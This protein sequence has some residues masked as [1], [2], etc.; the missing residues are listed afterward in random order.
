MDFI[1]WNDES[2]QKLGTQVYIENT[3]IE[4]SENSI[5]QINVA[6]GELKGEK[7]GYLFLK[8]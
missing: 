7:I 5:L 8:T 2:T 1:P 6:M 4:E 3:I